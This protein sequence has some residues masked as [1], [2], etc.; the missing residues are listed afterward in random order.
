M[1]KENL[2]ISFNDSLA[3]VFNPK[4]S[5]TNSIPLNSLANLTYKHNLIVCNKALL[6]NVIPANTLNNAVKDILYLYAVL[7][8]VKFT[9]G[10]II[11]L[12]KTLKLPHPT[13]LSKQANALY[14]I[15]NTLLKNLSSFNIGKQKSILSISNYIAQNN[16]YWEWSN[17]INK[18]LAHIK[19]KGSNLEKVWKNFSNVETTKNHNTASNTTNNISEELVL[20]TLND[21]TKKYQK[22]RESQKKYALEIAKIFNNSNI[23]TAKDTANPEKLDYKTKIVFAE[24][25]T[26]IGK[27]IGYLSA[28]IAFIKNNPNSSVVISTFSKTLQQQIIQELNTNLLETPN[29]I[30]ATLIKGNQNYACLLNVEYILNSIKSY[31]GGQL[32]LGFILRWLQETQNGDLLGGDF[33]PFLKDIIPKEIIVNILNKKDECIY[34][35]CNHYKKCFITK[36]KEETKNSNII[37]SNHS[38]TLL[39]NFKSDYFIFD[40]AHNLYHVS[41]EAFCKELSANK[42]IFLKSWLLGSSSKFSTSKTLLNGLQARLNTILAFIEDTDYNLHTNQNTNDTH[43]KNIVEGTVVAENQQ[44]I[45]NLK[46]KT[47]INTLTYSISFLPSTNYLNNIINHSP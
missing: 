45:I 22:P 19:L 10:S 23:I 41:D 8:P 16:N 39:N 35:K 33:L 5:V 11:G 46:I 32:F 36:I 40:E 43:L 26:G 34:T 15:Y 17:E 20:S 14:N 2:F 28:A 13:N 42:A 9:S 1:F 29:K 25:G 24:A 3:C 31:S 44:E 27:T 18:A 21:L 7:L 30:K 6:R 37:I 12:A 38:L 4:T 47:L